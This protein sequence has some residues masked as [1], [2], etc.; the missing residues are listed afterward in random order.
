MNQPSQAIDLITSDALSIVD[1]CKSGIGIQVFDDVA[2]FLNVP[3]VK[4]AN[5][6]RIPKSTLIRR[7]RSGHFNFEESERLVRILKVF[8]LATE[9][10]E[11][12][13]NASEWLNTTSPDFKGKTPL[14][15]LGSEH[16]ARE[17]EAVLERI[18][19]G[20]IF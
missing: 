15:Y 13:E 4:L 12:E 1:A 6:I 9:V 3:I 17:V 5:V 7:K 14:D 11:T 16:G 20:V 8:K 19:Y 10:L 2:N 18:A